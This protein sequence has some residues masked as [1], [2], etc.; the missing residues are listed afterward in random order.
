MSSLAQYPPII[1]SL[2]EEYDQIPPEENRA[3]DLVN[4]FFVSPKSKMRDK[5][6]APVA[7]DSENKS[8]AEEKDN[9]GESSDGVEAKKDDEFENGP[10]PVYTA[11]QIEKLRTLQNK[12]TKLL[13]KHGRSHAKTQAALNQV[14][15]HFSIFKLTVKRLNKSI[16]TIRSLL[17]KTREHEQ[18]ILKYVVKR[19]DTPRKGFISSFSKNETNENGYPSMLN[20]IPIKL[21]H[22]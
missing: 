3:F 5:A 22:C 13:Q 11:E 4:G 6:Q 15:E 7:T 21:A 19:A 17:K 9:K 1:D 12:F 8:K 10:C 14:S 18:S 16:T 20:S 2:I